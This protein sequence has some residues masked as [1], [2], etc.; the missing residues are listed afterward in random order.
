M[1]N[2][3]TTLLFRW[4][5]E[6]WN[7]SKKDSIDKLLTKDVIAHGLGPDGQLQG[8]ESFK[9]FYDDFRNQ[10]K[11]IH[12]HIEDVICQDDIETALCKV[13]AVDE[14][15]GKEIKFSGICMAKIE[16]GKIA[17]AWN[18]YDFLKMYQQLGFVLTLQ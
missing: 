2:I 18:Y 17:Q 10:L 16:N 5:Q 4:F 9:N 3:K 12:V 14:A 7:E 6:V 15:S 1:R 13:T 8:I 11:N